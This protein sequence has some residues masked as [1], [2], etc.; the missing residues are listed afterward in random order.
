MAGFSKQ[1]LNRA[2]K[3]NKKNIEVECD[4]L[5]MIF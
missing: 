5:S 2:S 1:L 4:V 3:K